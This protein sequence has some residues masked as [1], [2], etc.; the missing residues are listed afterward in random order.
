MAY[1]RFIKNGQ[2]LHTQTAPHAVA[3]TDS[4]SLGMYKIPGSN[5]FRMDA[6]INQT[7]GLGNPGTDSMMSMY[8]A[9]PLLLKEQDFNNLW[10]GDGMLRTIVNQVVLDGMR[11]GYDFNGL[12]PDVERM[13]KNRFNQLHVDMVIRDWWRWGRLH[14]GAAILMGIDDGNDDLTVPFEPTQSKYK[15]L[16]LKV[17]DR[18]RVLPVPEIEINPDNPNFGKIVKWR[19]CPLTGGSFDVHESRLIIYDGEPVTDQQRI[20]QNWWGDSV[21]THCYT[22][23]RG[24]RNVLMNVDKIVEAY[25]QPVLKVQGFAAKVESGQGD[26]IRRRLLFMDMCRS[27]LR[28]ILLDSE[29]EYERIVS[30]LAGLEDAITKYVEMLAGSS[31]VPIKIL[32]G[33]AP[34]GL[35]ATGESDMQQW[36]DY[37]NSEQEHRPEFAIRR[38][39]DVVS[40]ESDVQ[41]P[42][43]DIKFKSLWQPSDDT[44]AKTRLAHAQTDQIYALLGSLTSEEIRDHR[45]AQP[46]Y[47]NEIAGIDRSE[48]PDLLAE[49]TDEPSIASMYA[50]TAVKPGNLKSEEGMGPSNGAAL[51]SSAGAIGSNN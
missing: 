14:G 30:S 35:N 20:R 6:W 28:T 43:Y 32:V 48:D 40:G 46:E 3:R 33:T 50:V 51:Q 49:S 39:V 42:E 8:P 31:R 4:R 9:S 44:Q 37:V 5:A 18:W 23:L 27:T 45:F 24:L 10:R 26:E 36:Y 2:T 21:A 47:G 11:A 12:D 34:K 13:I 17:F 38:L 41:L 1:A 29:E 25:V 22:D 19:I 16:Y 15:I 7:T